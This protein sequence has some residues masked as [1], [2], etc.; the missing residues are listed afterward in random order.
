MAS[1]K[2][3]P[4]L[5]VHAPVGRVALH[6]RPDTVSDSEMTSM[7]PAPVFSCSRMSQAPAS[8]VMRVTVPL[9]VDTV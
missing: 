5:R 1:D 8:D 2:E 4:S 9:R 3:P 7:A 6:P